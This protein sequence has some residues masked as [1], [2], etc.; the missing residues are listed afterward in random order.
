M[1]G[2]GSVDENGTGREVDVGWVEGGGKGGKLTMVLLGG[3]GEGAFF[4]R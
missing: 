4:N 2:V 3:K 1:S